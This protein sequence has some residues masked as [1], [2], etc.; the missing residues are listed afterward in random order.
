[1][2]RIPEA[3]ATSRPQGS[4]SRRGRLTRAPGS[5]ERCLHG[6]QQTCPVL[7]K[8]ENGPFCPPGL[9]RFAFFAAGTLARNGKQKVSSSLSELSCQAEDLVV[10]LWR[11]W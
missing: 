9:T 11:T 5:G 2:V 10:P 1:M 3:G 4:A 6:G 7:R 8:P